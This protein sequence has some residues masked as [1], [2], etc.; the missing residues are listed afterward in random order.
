MKPA[1]PCAFLPFFGAGGGEGAVAATAPRLLVVLEEGAAAEVV[2]EF[3]PLA[4]AAG[5]YLVNSGGR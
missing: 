2:E 3:A 5:S 4:V 1:V